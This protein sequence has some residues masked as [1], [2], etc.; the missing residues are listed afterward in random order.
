MRVDGTARMVIQV[1]LSR[2]EGRYEGGLG[3]QKLV[4]LGAV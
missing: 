1:A 2:C 4:A 3:T